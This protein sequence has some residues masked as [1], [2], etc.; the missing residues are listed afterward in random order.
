MVKNDKTRLARTRIACLPASICFWVETLEMNLGNVEC[1][2]LVAENKSFARAA[3][4]LH[5]SQPAV[6]KQ[7]QAL[8]KKMGVKLFIQSRPYLSVFIELA[9]KMF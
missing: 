9:S 1:F 6:T 3:K 5:I 2:L 8:E 4:A 7:I